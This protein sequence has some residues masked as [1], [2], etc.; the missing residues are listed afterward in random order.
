MNNLDGF[1][2]NEER[3]LEQD[4]F[5]T[6]LKKEKFINDIKGGLGNEIVKQ[7]NTVQKKISFWGKIKKLVGWI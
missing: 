5:V 1:I 4:K 3:K 2:K 6:E 7:P